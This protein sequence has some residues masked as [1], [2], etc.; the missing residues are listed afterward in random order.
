MPLN[1][2]GEWRF[3][4]PVLCLVGWLA[5][6]SSR[7]TSVEMLPSKVLARDS[8]CGCR[9]EERSLPWT[10]IQARF[11]GG[12]ARRLVTN[13]T[14]ISAPNVMLALHYMLYWRI[15]TLSYS[16]D[17]QPGVRTGI[18]MGTRKKLNNYI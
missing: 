11:T 14:A 7:F 5:S 12:L 17:S 13:V 9:R 2:T 18:F 16:I 4:I 8:L 10:E 1:Y 6:C 15:H 3:L